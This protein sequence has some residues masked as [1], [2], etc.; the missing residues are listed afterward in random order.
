MNTIRLTISLAT[1]QLVISISEATIGSLNCSPTKEGHESFVTVVWN[2]QISMSVCKGSRVNDPNGQSRLTI[3]IRNATNKGETPTSGH[4]TLSYFGQNSNIN[5]TC[6]V[7]DRSVIFS[8]VSTVQLQSF[9]I[10][11]NCTIT[12][13]N[14][15]FIVETSDR[16]DCQPI[17]SQDKLQIKCSSDKIY[18]T[19]I[20]KF[21]A[22]PSLKGDSV[23]IQ[24]N[25]E[26]PDT[27]SHINSTCTADMFVSKLTSPKLTVNVTM[28]P[29]VTG[30]E[31]DIRYGTNKS[32]TYDFETNA[33][34]CSPALKGTRNTL[35]LIWDTQWPISLY[36]N[37]RL[38]MS[39]GSVNSCELNNN[40][41]MNAIY[42]MDGN[43]SHMVLS[44][45]DVGKNSIDGQWTM[46]YLGLSNSVRT[47]CTVVAW[48]ETIECHKEIDNEGVTVM[49]HTSL[50]STKAKCFFRMNH[51][52]GSAAGVT[53]LKGEI[54]YNH[55]QVGLKPDYYNS[56]CSLNLPWVSFP[57][58]QF[59]VTVLMFPNVTGNDSDQQYGL[60]SSK[61]D[62]GVP[63]MTLN[64][65][66]IRVEKGT[67][68]SCL[69][70]SS[71]KSVPAAWFADE[72]NQFLTNDVISFTAHRLTAFRCQSS[73]QKTYFGMHQIYR[74][75]IT[76]PPVVRGRH[77]SNTNDTPGDSTL[78]IFCNDTKSVLKRR[79]DIY[80]WT[81]TDFISQVDENKFICDEYD[82]YE[83]VMIDA[84]NDTNQW[85]TALCSAEKI[86]SYF[87]TTVIASS[88][89]G[90]VA[91]IFVTWILIYC[92]R[93]RIADPQM[94]YQSGSELDV[95]FYKNYDLPTESARNS[96]YVQ[97]F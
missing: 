86:D 17:I 28:Y 77:A 74:P 94:S 27:T 75:E 50:I 62:V 56:S 66:P 37:D 26:I 83:C 12:H 24:Y 54:K 67:N 85:S 61:I 9:Y 7:Y 95:S 64:D 31:D 58:A 22:T 34:S 45:R 59:Q 5:I 39:C 33:L 89:C 25:Q 30:S 44:G 2:S 87:L 43:M 71:L 11:Q 88:V 72:T 6:I 29:N 10:F 40:D 76:Y 32:I 70:T 68:V 36:R 35:N 47:S 8:L 18:P 19:A 79:D 69:C 23:T 51:T 55:S 13:S 20:C 96:V 38:V 78:F 91:V 63:H 49:C 60:T 48:M 65:C 53:D 14:L 93:R 57:A 90:L 46:K 81:N 3:K 41:F 97:H 4:W 82:F 1:L 80:H 73:K 16:I 15:F 21:W 92:I 84:D 42:R 52:S